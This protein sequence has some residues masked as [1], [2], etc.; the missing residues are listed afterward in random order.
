MDTSLDLIA[1]IIAAISLI[2][3]LRSA[4]DRQR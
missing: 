3:Q 1:V 2:V 4:P